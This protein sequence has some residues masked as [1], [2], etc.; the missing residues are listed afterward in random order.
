MFRCNVEEKERNVWGN[1]RKWVEKGKRIGKNRKNGVQ[2]GQLIL[3]R[4]LPG[5]SLPGDRA[6]V[7]G[8]IA[9]YRSPM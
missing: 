1:H 3:A 5:A 7:K 6:T 4:S 9:V 2:G 8:W